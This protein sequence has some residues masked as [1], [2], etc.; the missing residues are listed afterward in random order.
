[1]ASLLA[2]P[3]RTALSVA[4]ALR[5]NS[6]SQVRV[7]RDPHFFLALLTPRRRIPARVATVS[8]FLTVGSWI[9]E[10]MC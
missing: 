10:A 9:P 5:M 2:L 8:V 1:V 4:K 3:L 6:A 7:R